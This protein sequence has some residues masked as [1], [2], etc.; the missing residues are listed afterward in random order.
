MLEFLIQFAIEATRIIVPIII[1]FG[2]VSNS[3][4]ILILTRPG[5]FRHACSLYFIGRAISNLFYTTVMLTINL[6]ADGYQLDLT[7]YSNFTC[8]MI[9][10]FL[11]LCP[12][13]SAYF[14]VLASIDRYCA[15]SANVRIRDFSCIRVARWTIGIL[16]SILMIFFIWAL[17]AFELVTFGLCICLIDSTLLSSQIFLIIVI[18]LYAVLA[19]FCMIVFGFLTIKNANPL[20][21]IRNRTSHFR[22]TQCQ[23]S[24]MLLLQV[25]THI[26]L[27]LPFCIGFFIFILPI[28]L[29][30]SLEFYYIFIISKLPLYLSFITPFFLYILSAQV[31]RAEL[32]RLV[33]KIYPF[34]RGNKVHTITNPKPILTTNRRLPMH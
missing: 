2:I 4:N 20:H 25:G 32:I 16:I 6:L 9:T 28:P 1:I 5:L 15:S 24:R 23:L 7:L 11:N 18:T 30:F 10:Y 14:I 8:K 17:V 34:H 21:L 29:R 33:K 31:Y 26:I 22:R 12:N 3:L 13:I 19:P 27:S